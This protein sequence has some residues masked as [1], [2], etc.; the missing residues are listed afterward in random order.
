MRK[1]GGGGRETRVEP[2]KASKNEKG[3]PRYW[4]GG[5]RG[6][7]GRA[8]GGNCGQKVEWRKKARGGRRAEQGCESRMPDK[9]KGGAAH[10]RGRN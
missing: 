10:N 1:I 9:I 4:G 6:V 8:G 2:E 5:S 3:N 7:R